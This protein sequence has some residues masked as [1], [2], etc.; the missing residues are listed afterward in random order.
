MNTETIEPDVNTHQ[1]LLLAAAEGLYGAPGELTPEARHI[2]RALIEGVLSA[3]RAGGFTQ[4]DI[5]ATM[6][7]NCEISARTRS[8]ARQAC[9]AAS[10]A[11]LRQ[12]FER[13]G[14]AEG[15]GAA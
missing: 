12:L 1:G 13:I 5:L 14:L 10:T 6:L 2:A 8:M 7:A 11:A 15:M 9:A 4:A 3:A